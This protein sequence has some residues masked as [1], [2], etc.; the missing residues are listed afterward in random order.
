MAILDYGWIHIERGGA[1]AFDL[2]C[3]KWH[4]NI[5]WNL[6]ETVQDLPGDIH[7]GFDMQV[8]GREIIL[9]E[10]YFKTSEDVE[11]FI[12][13]AQVINAAGKAT[14]EI[15][16]TSDAV[17]GSLFEFKSGVTS[18]EM[19]FI[20]VATL[21]KVGRGNSDVYMVQTVKLRQAG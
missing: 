1:N 13:K 7:I 17:P 2:G 19:L 21:Q 10:V 5:T 11:T 12:N 3:K 9:T 20:Q 14:L 18:L 6:M 16:K 4:L 8:I 15:Q